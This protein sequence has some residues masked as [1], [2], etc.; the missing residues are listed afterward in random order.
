MSYYVFNLPFF[1]HNLQRDN[2]KKGHLYL[3]RNEPWITEFLSKN[4]AVKSEDG[5][6]I[7]TL[8]G[9]KFKNTVEVEDFLIVL[10]RTI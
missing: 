9:P 2:F 4:Q 6:M 8:E 3:K 10:K 1:Q 7:V 5:K